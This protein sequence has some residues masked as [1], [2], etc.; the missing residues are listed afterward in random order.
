MKDR[1]CNFKI[2]WLPMPTYPV[3]INYIAIAWC[4][5]YYSFA[6]KGN[7]QNKG[8]KLVA[9]W[10]IIIGFLAPKMLQAPN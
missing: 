1:G 7:T 5:N 9:H 10:S 8:W 6:H 3:A 2:K 4:N